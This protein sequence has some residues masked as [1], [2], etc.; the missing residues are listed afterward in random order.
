MAKKTAS[1]TISVTKDVAEALEYIAERFDL[2]SVEEAVLKCIGSSETEGGF[3]GRQVACDTY[4]G[5]A[6]KVREAIREGKALPGDVKFRRYVAAFRQAK[7]D[8]AGTE[9]DVAKWVRAAPER[10]HV[11]AEAHAKAAK[12]ADKAR[13]RTQ[14][15][16]PATPAA[17]ETPAAQ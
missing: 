6:A 15:E 14:A 13:A 10:A 11:Y 12:A 1:I 16:K 5:K 2:E 17:T 7:L 9:T 3:Y 8:A 4:A